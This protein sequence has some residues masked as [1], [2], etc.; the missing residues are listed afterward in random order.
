MDPKVNGQLQ[1][2][3][4][5]LI[6]IYLFLG[7]VGA[8]AYTIAAINGFIGEELALSTTVGL[9]ISFPA[10]MIGSAVLLADLGSPTKAIFAGKKLG[11]S[12]I[13]RGFWIISIFMIL[14]FIHFLLHRSGIP[15]GSPSITVVSI[16]GIVFAVST[17]AYTGV[18]L[19]AS[20]GVPFWRSGIVPVVFVVSALVTGHFSVMLGVVLLGGVSAFPDPLRTMALEAAILVAL[21]VLAI[22]FFLQAAFKTPDTRESAERILQKR[23]FVFGYFALGLAVPLI[24]ML[25]VTRMQGFGGGALPLVFLGALLGLAGG[26]ILRQAILVCGT[27][28]TWNIAGF[29]FRRIARPKEP[30][31]AMGMLPPH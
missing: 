15:A 24:L 16:L 23:S 13:A 1:T 21:E 17:M 22:V 10:L 4:G 29:K 3:W 14:A 20:K 25:Y 31:P 5:W 6:A 30:K 28:P 19:G 11:S 9:W 2:E 8:G 18:L 26:L 27:L 7:G 12:W